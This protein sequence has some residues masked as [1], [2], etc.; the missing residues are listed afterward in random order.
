MQNSMTSTVFGWYQGVYVINSF[1][2]GNPK[3]FTSNV[4]TGK[5]LIPQV[6]ALQKLL[7]LSHS[8]SRNTVTH[9]RQFEQFLCYTL[10]HP[11]TLHGFPVKS[12]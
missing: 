11:W 10:Q 12:N 2:W 4:V 8:A 6:N 1:P 3:K 7:E 5:H 9:A